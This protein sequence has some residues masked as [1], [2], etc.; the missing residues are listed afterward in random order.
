[1][2]VTLNKQ[3]KALDQR[4]LDHWIDDTHFHWQSQ[5]GATPASK[6]GQDIIHHDHLGI[7]LHL[8]IRENK[9]LNG[10]AAPFVYQGLARY[11][12]HTGSAPISVIFETEGK[13]S[14]SRT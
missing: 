11:R 14:A 7:T 1:M 4:Y 13:M 8:F 2:F 5:N 10:K 9:L 3:G 12:S 6:R